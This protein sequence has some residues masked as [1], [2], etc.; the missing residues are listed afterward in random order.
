VILGPLQLLV[1]GSGAGLLA[2][3]GR[4]RQPGLGVPRPRGLLVDEPVPLPARVGV[5]ALPA[6]LALVLA[7]LGSVS[8][9]R[10]AGGA[11]E[12]AQARCP[13]RALFLEALGRRGVSV[14]SEDAV[15]DELTAV[16]GRAAG[17][18]LTRKDIMAVR[19]AIVACDAHTLGPSGVLMVPWKNGASHDASSTHVVAAIDARGLVAIACYEEP[20][21]GLAVPALGLLAPAFASPVMRGEARVRPGEPRPAAA[22]IALRIL[23]GVADLAAGLAEASD[24]QASLEIVMSALS[25]DRTVAAAMALAP[26]GRPVAIVRDRDGGRIVASA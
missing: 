17:G 24:A 15:S 21:E 11:I 8:Q 22:P 4:V 26:S 9:L 23:R 25:D 18:L 5:P 12:R 14:M 13:E 10:L 19:P 2:I 3:D 16:A 20:L 7:S 1:S 6:S